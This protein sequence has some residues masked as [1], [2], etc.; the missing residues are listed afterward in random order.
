MVE[1]C[2]SLKVSQQYMCVEAHL[3]LPVSPFTVCK[4]LE[5]ICLSVLC[6]YH[7]CRYICVCP[8]PLSYVSEHKWYISSVHSSTYVSLSFCKVCLCVSAKSVCLSVCVC[9]C[10]CV[11]VCVLL[12]LSA[13][14]RITDFNI[15]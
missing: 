2:G 13:S 6:H 5:G 1:V 7:M 14:S 8:V 15:I 9:M 11:C 10:V 4:L 12:S 3:I